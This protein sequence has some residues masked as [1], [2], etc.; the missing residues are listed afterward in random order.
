MDTPVDRAY[1]AIALSRTDT[2]GLTEKNNDREIRIMCGKEFSSK[3]ERNGEMNSRLEFIRF[4]HCNLCPGI[5]ISNS[6]QEI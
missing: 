5:D 6:M 1:H 2:K 4:L 3:E